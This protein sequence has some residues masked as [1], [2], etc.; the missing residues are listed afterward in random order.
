ME[1]ACSI[2]HLG[3]SPWLADLMD[4]LKR[5]A[6]RLANWARFASDYPKPIIIFIEVIRLVLIEDF[7]FC[8]CPF[9]MNFVRNLPRIRRASI[10]STVFRSSKCETWHGPVF[11]TQKTPIYCSFFFGKYEQHIK[12]KLFPVSYPLNLHTSSLK[13]PSNSERIYFSP[14]FFFLPQ[15][16]YCISN[17][18]TAR[19]PEFTFS[20]PAAEPF[21]NW[22]CI[23][24]VH[25]NNMQVS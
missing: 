25:F 7:S 18:Q 5:N 23:L 8:C 16:F 17:C 14:L 12:R 21:A 11:K 4:S 20:P 15:N 6:I 1:C 19:G 2:L 24:Y 22:L 3:I 10:F 13:R 9:V